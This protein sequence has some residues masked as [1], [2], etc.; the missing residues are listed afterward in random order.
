MNVKKLA[1]VITDIEALPVSTAKLGMRVNLFGVINQ[2]EQALNDMAIP[3]ENASE[4]IV[5]QFENRL[6]ESQ[7]IYHA[8]ALG[9]LSTHLA[10]L[11]AAI[12]DGDAKTVRLFFE[13]YGLE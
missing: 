3:F 6:M 9:Q 10:L 13:M 8:F 5:E 4:H 11:K 2:A 1:K 7:P 12:Q